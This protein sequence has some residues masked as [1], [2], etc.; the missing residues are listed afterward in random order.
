MKLFNLKAETQKLNSPQIISLLQAIE[1]YKGKTFSIPKMSKLNRLHAQSKRRS[2]TSSNAIENI[3]V[4]KLREEELLKK[5]LDP[6]THDDFMLLGYNKS[7]ELVYQVYKY[8]PLDVSFVLTLHQYLYRGWNPAFG[9][10]FKDSQNYIQE[11]ASD[12]T[13][14]TVFVPPSPFETPMLTDNLISLFNE[15]M[16]DPEVNRLLLIFVFILDFLCIH[17]FNDGNGRTSR[18]LSSFLLM[19]IGYDIDLFY[20]LSYLILN[21]IDEYY[22]ALGESDKGWHEG[23]NDYSYFVVFMLK[24]MLEGYQK[25]DYL[26]ECNSLVGNAEDKVLKVIVD[27]ATPISKQDIEEILFSLSR[28]TIEK[29]LGSLVGTKIQIVTKG[30]YSRYFRL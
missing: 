28:F 22:D 3:S 29:A 10:K 13:R 4:S 30:R 7:L 11:I 6:Q 18:L 5:G 14:K 24:I 2:I 21:H 23:T 8:Q 20:S 26:M 9:G 27:S 17:P 16:K 25:L 15:C 1:L 12:G 19:K